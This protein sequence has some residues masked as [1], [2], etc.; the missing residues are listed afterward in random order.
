MR[1]GLRGQ[2]GPATGAPLILLIIVVL[3]LYIIMLPPESREELLSSGTVSVPGS[4][5][6]TPGSGVSDTQYVFEGP[7][8]IDFISRHEYHHEIPAQSLYSSTSAAIIHRENDFIVERGV[9]AEIIY[10]TTFHR[11][12]M[13]QQPALTFRAPVREGVL[14]VRLNGE[15]IYR[16]RVHSDNPV[17]V[18]IAEHKLQQMNTLEFEVDRS[19]LRF[20]RRNMYS[21]VDLT[22]QGDVRDASQSHGEATFSMRSV[23]A[24]YLD[25]ATLRFIPEC[26]QG[27]VGPLSGYI[28]NV[29]IFSRVPDCG[30]TNVF[31]IDPSILREGMN[32]VSFSAQEGSY[33][34]DNIRVTTLLE[35]TRDYVYYFH[36]N[37][38]YFVLDVTTQPICGIIDGQCPAN[39]GADLDKDC[40]FQQYTQGYWCDVPTTLRSD[41]CV[42]TVTDFNVLRCP[43][44]YRDRHGKPP[45]D[46]KGMCG[47][48]TDGVCPIGCSAQY[49]KDC[50]LAQ[51]GNNYFCED[52][53]ITG[54]ADR[55]VSEVSPDMCHLCAS[56][57][58]GSS[59]APAA[60]SIPQDKVEE[61]LLR[62]QYKVTAQLIF[63]HD[64]HDKIGTVLINGHPTRIDTRQS[65]VEID[66]S[67]FVKDHSNYI[68]IIP[69]SR[70]H[71]I[72]VRID[73]SRT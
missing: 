17:L 7:G 30:I 46:F 6:G 13:L 47:D 22:I 72:E 24:Q 59:G 45:A 37:P 39:C 4:T 11:P 33:I 1:R 69:E 68:Q 73:V 63:L 50:C 3:V 49:D 66:I 54:V 25:R 27:Q 2:T 60:C 5:P 29:R 65:T 16:N 31:A 8:D 58:K 20:W 34:I 28:N 44:G 32:S 42:G 70:M 57:Y 38:N 56:G 41:R 52:M 64:S 14:T 23:E 67:R 55:C 35:D 71:L 10:S 19:P 48:N 40:C 53:P 9:F 18:R 26:A 36:L 15:Q 21:I 61:R 51:S 43:S 62:S 12:A